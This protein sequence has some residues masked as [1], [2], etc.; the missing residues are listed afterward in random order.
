VYPI[1]HTPTAFIGRAQETHDISDLLA[2]P[3]CR[4]LTLVGPGGIGK[5]RLAMEV[6]THQQECFP[7]GIYFVPLAPLTRADDILT[8]IVEA[9]PFRFQSNNQSPLSQFLDYLRDKRAKPM[10][11]ILDNF[12]HLLEGVGII[13][14]ILAVTERVKILVTSREPLNLQE[15]WVRHLSGLTYPTHDPNGTFEAYGAVQLFI[16]RARRIRGDFNSTQERQSIL[17]ICR[18][19]EGMPL[20]IELAAGWLNTLQPAEIAQEIRDNLN[21]LATRSRNLPER[22]RS[23]RSVFEQSWR[24]LSDTERK[25]FCRLSLFRGGFTRA[26]ATAVTGTDLITLA[27]LVDK[28]LVR[29]NGNGRYDIH[30]LLRQYGAEQLEATHETAPVQR[31]YFTYYLNLLHELEPDIKSHR[32]IIALDAIEAD[33][34]NIRNAWLLAVEEKGFESLGQAVESVQFFADMRGRYHDG[35]ALLQAAIAHF[36][37][38]PTADQSAIR[39]RIQARLIRLLLLGNIKIGIDLRSQIDDCLAI[40][41]SRQEPAEIGFCLLISGIVAV[42]EAN[43][44]RPYD[45]IQ[46]APLFRESYECYQAVGDIFY[47]AEALSWVA[48]TP[49]LPN[50]DALPDDDLLEVSLGLRRT[51]G[52]KNGIAWN[53]MNLTEITLLA[54][55]YPACERYARETLTLMGEI[56]SIKG[57]LQSA[58]KLALTVMLRGEFAEA[59]ALIERMRDLAE[60]TNNLNG[61]MVSAGLLSFLWCVMDEAYTEGAVLAE[62]TIAL[63]QESFFGGHK[64]LGMFWGKTLADIGLGQYGTARRKYAALFWDRH[65]D[66]GPASVCLAVEA[67]IRAHEGAPESAVELLG[68]A[69]QQPLYVS[70]WLH[71]W[72]LMA[73]LQE[74]LKAQLGESRFH[75]AWERGKH[76]DLETIIHRL[77]AESTAILNTPPP[78]SLIEP[79]SERE[80][81]VLGLIAEGLS[82]R[83]IAERLVLTVGTVKVHTRNIYGKLGVGSRTQAIAEAGKLKL[84]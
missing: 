33:F 52:D 18:L 30:E 39:G 42:W 63:S 82:N 26:A 7:A 69:F 31:C 83:E 53:I 60:E 66:P 5:T 50:S 8:A 40:A 13:P 9:T 48:C 78:Q 29:L 14:D 59:L 49:Q 10:L 41:R 3:S 28:S 47:E 70:G 55:D 38:T 54:L 67:T 11:F 12:E 16:E 1:T 79:L 15:E 71:Q 84:L 45:N 35:V 22:H 36:P 64:D 80:L 75:A 73:R 77:L 17:E 57:I 24:L 46:A 43:D 37:P 4:L 44:E 21:F 20:A 27:A 76:H 34:E 68:L 23:I 81:E 56:R 62:K 32:Q 72:A 58:S 6:A 25:V 61:K 65:D 74:S 2:D 51:I 19:V